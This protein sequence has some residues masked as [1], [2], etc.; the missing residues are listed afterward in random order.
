MNLAPY[1]R[2]GLNYVIKLID[3]FVANLVVGYITLLY[4]P[5]PRSVIV[6][7]VINMNQF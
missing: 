4:S 7:I 1:L 5:V 3:I 6:I 2:P